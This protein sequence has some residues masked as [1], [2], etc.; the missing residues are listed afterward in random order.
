MSTTISAPPDVKRIL[1][2]E[3]EAALRLLL[4]LMLRKRGYFVESVEDGFSALRLLS[5]KPWDLII[6]DL[7]MP[8]MDGEALA[9]EIKKRDPTK[10]I[11]LISGLSNRFVVRP[12]LFEA[13]L[14]KPFSADNLY[15]CLSTIAG[16]AT[17][18]S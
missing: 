10:P 8:K 14:E 2:V 1:L 3:D 6:T 9:N 18:R 15:A 7:M 16:F 12:H 5:D 4:P 17:P 13:I 11:V